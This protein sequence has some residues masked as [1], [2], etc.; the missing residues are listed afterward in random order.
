[1]HHFP[2]PGMEQ[3][4]DEDAEGDKGN[5]DGGERIDLRGQAIFHAGVH[6]HGQGGG[7]GPRHKAGD[8]HI[9]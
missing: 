7:L 1:M 6:D 3:S 9:V 4:G 8:Y 2:M 5:D